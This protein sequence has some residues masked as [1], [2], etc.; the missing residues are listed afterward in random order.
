MLNKI[1]AF[2]IRNKLIVGMM[3]LALIITGIYNVTKL[4]IDAV[5]DITNNQVMVITLRHLW[6]L[7]ILKG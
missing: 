7:L 6:A 4:P 5:P 3:V 2:S 1:I